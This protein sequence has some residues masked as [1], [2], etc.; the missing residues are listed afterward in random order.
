MTVH[1]HRQT[2]YPIAECLALLPNLHTLEITT[3]DHSSTTIESAFWSVRL[4]RVRTLVV[5][6]DAHH[7]IWCCQNVEHVLMYRYSRRPIPYVRSIVH[8]KRSITRVG[9]CAFRPLIVEGA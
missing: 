5:D 7:I 2:I 8:V 6:P 1:L 9:L 4:P 3:S